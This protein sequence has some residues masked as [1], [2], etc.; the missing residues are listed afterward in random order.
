MCAASQFGAVLDM[1]TD[2]ACTN[3]LL[4]VLASSFTTYL[5]D[6]EPVWGP[7]AG[8][9]VWLSFMLLA[10]LDLV[11]HWVKMN[12]SLLAGRSSHKTV[13]ADRFF[14]LRVYYTSRPVLFAVCALNELCLALLY[15]GANVQADQHTQVQVPGFLARPFLSD[16]ADWPEVSLV[17]LGVFVT[18]PV[19]LLK[20]AISVLQLADALHELALLDGLALARED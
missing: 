18:A 8:V 19:F 6:E 17:W 2:R 7:E 20:Q 1:V 4:L 13:D 14:L 16:K 10:V 9:W 15:V 5:K 11:S 3:V 12:V